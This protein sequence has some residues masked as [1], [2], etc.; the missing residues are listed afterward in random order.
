MRFLHLIF[1]IA[2]VVVFLLTGQYMDKYLH[3]LG[4]MPDGPRMLYRTRHIYILM[5]GL[6]HLALAAYLV[7]RTA[8]W[9]RVLQWLGSVV[10]ITSSLLFVAA[11]FYDSRRGDLAAPLSRQA[12]FALAYGTL[13]HLFSLLG[14]SRA[15]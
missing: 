1:G 12:I 15:A 3:H 11:F 6:V 9:Q 4:G 14:K 13:F 5:S 8:G 10:L 2:I 7:V